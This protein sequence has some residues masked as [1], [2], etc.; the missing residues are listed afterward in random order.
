MFLATGIPFCLSAQTARV[1]FRDTS[2]R[3]VMIDPSTLKQVS[4]KAVGHDNKEHEYSGV[5][6]S[7]IISAAGVQL[8]EP[9]KRSTVATYL[10]IRAKDD[11]QCLYAL[12]ELDPLFTDRQI[13]LA[14]KVDHVALS[15][16]N[17]PFQVIAPGEKKHGRWI[18]QVI[19]MELKSP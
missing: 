12:A 15:A 8:G 4:V 10:L 19:S 11:Y 3:S 14:D 7:D 17:G 9:A 13:I 2:G 18:R 16:D 1:E 5:L 6:L